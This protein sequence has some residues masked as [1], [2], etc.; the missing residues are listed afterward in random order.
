MA[1]RTPVCTAFCSQT[2]TK[3]LMLGQIHCSYLKREKLCVP[4]C[5]LYES[6]R[7]GCVGRLPNST[8]KEEKHKINGHVDRYG[9][10]SLHASF[11]AF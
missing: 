3:T 2:A 8:Q 5:H 7:V 6:V 10:N 4:V 9:Q 1:T 11:F